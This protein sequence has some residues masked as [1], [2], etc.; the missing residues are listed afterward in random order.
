MDVHEYEYLAEF[1]ANKTKTNLEYKHFKYA[2]DLVKW[3]N[4][5]AVEVISISDAGKFSE[6]QIL[7]YRLCQ[8]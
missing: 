4:A 3:V 8:D 1:G 5:N 6:G 2:R 7:Y